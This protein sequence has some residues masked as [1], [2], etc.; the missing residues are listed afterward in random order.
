MCQFYLNKTEKN[1]N[2][3]HAGKYRKLEEK[4]NELSQSKRLQTQSSQLQKEN[5]ACK[6]H[7]NIPP[8]PLPKATSVLTSN[9]KLQICIE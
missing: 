6:G 5:M 8:S 9:T 1:K 7:P 2:R 4:L 3:R